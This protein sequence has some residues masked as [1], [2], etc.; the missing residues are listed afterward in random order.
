MA[1]ARLQHETCCA[2]PAARDKKSVW[3]RN[4]IE[5]KGER[6]GRRSRG[7]GEERFKSTIYFTGILLGAGLSRREIIK[8][9]PLPRARRWHRDAQGE[10]PAVSVILSAG[11]YFISKENPGCVCELRAGWGGAM[12]CQPW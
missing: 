6:R 5:E 11:I 10:E 2:D 12:P 9:I 3:K 7:R 4:G 8:G 1:Q